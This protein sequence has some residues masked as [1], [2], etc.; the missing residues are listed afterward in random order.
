MSRGQH[1]GS[2]LWLFDQYNL[3]ESIELC[4]IG[5]T[6]VFVLMFVRNIYLTGW[7]WKLLANTNW[8]I[9]NSKIKFFVVVER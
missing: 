3:R 2:S 8:M 6:R 7:K 1:Q 4:P 9:T 5:D